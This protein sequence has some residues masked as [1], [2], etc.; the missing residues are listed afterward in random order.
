LSR[1]KIVK[2]KD[3]QGER[4]PEEKIV[5]WKDRQGKRSSGEKVVGKK[6]VWKKI[7]EQ[8]CRGKR[9]SGTKIVWEKI[10]GVK[11]CR[12]KR[13]S[14]E[15]IVREK[16]V[17]DSHHLPPTTMSS[18]RGWP[19]S[20]SQVDKAQKKIY[21]GVF[22]RWLGW[23]F[24]AAPCYAGQLKKIAVPITATARQLHFSRVDMRGGDGVSAKPSYLITYGRSFRLP[25]RP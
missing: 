12:W 24:R 13:S 6:I 3:H 1:V 20:A 4:S 22:P 18:R 17:W 7:E 9:L 5:R 15:K 25:A 16:F 2:R 14:G 21:R 10:V 23:L 19:V 8:D 11:D